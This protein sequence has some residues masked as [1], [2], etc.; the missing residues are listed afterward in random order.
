M[1]RL[2]I[3][4]FRATDR[5]CDLIDDNY[6]ALLVLSRFNIAL[7]FGDRTIG[8][9]CSENRVDAATFLAV[10]NLMYNDNRP[11]TQEKPQLSIECLI[12]YLY[13]SHH[14]F[15]KFRLPEMRRKLKE[16]L[17]DG[18]SDLNNAMIGYFDNFVSALKKHTFTEN[19]KIFPYVRALLNGEAPSKMLIT[20][21][22]Q[23]EQI[24]FSLTEFKS[25]LIKYYP[26]VKANEIN[27]FLFDIFNC[28]KDLASHNAVEEYLFQPEI[29]ALEAKIRKTV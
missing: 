8:E 25:V 3:G 28:E 6:H 29:D 22:K 11:P 21:Q 13:N 1:N 5:M 27:S 20:L 26:A 4:K 24:Q 23:H 10:I 9:I 14:F 16:S 12:E 19:K 15:L 18:D 7:G 2:R 17:N